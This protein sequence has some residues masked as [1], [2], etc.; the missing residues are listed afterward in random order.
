MKQIDAGGLSFQDLRDCD[1][2]YVDKTLL[3]KDILDRNDRGIYLFA[4]PRRFGKTTN[5]SMLD[6][7]FNIEYKGNNWFDGLAISNY[8]E[9]ER[10]KNAFPVIKL[11]LKD[12]KCDDANHFLN[13]LKSTISAAY[14]DHAYLTK[15]DVLSER[16]KLNYE[17]IRFKNVE[18]DF[19]Q[20]CIPELCRLLKKYHGVNPIILIDEYGPCCIQFL[21]RGVPPQNN[22]LSRFVFVA[23]SQ[24]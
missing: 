22:E 7:F 16:E 23:D 10:Y 14:S 8:P 1:K 13:R 11:N 5:L 2:Y 4:R 17:E 9:Y 24:K 12:T 19:I 6:A 18:D 21:R 20:D 15:S 3:I